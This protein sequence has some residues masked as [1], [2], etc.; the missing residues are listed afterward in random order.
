MIRKVI[1]IRN[2]LYI[3]CCDLEGTIKVWNSIEYRSVINHQTINMAFNSLTLWFLNVT[4]KWVWLDLF[5]SYVWRKVDMVRYN[6][7]RR[8]W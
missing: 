6:V 5:T 8:E 7:A 3:V 1:N 4:I 2:G